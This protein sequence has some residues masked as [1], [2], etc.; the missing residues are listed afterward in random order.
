MSKRIRINVTKRDL[1]Q[2]RRFMPGSCPVARAV[3]RHEGF[4]KARVG[5]Y[6]ISTGTDGVAIDLPGRIANFISDFDQGIAVNPFS[7]SI[8]VPE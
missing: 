2:G 5:S 3:Q 7:F 8:E 6:S 1:E 4:E